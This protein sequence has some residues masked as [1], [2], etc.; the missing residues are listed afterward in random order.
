MNNIKITKKINSEPQI[1]RVFSRLNNNDFEWFHN[2]VKDHKL[3]NGSTELSV[4]ITVICKSK[5]EISKVCQ[6]LG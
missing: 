3:E 5:S 2:G 4:T 6:I 1:S